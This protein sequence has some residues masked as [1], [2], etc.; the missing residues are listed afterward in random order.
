MSLEVTSHILLNRIVSAYKIGLRWKSE[1]RDVVML[2]PNM[3][4]FVDFLYGYRSVQLRSNLWFGFDD[5]A[6]HPQI[7]DKRVPHLPLIP[8]AAG[9]GDDPRMEILWTELQEHDFEAASSA[10]TSAFIGLGTIRQSYRSFLELEFERV[11]KR[12]L[13]IEDEELKFNVTNDFRIRS[14]KHHGRFITRQLAHPATFQEL[15]IWCRRCQRLILEFYARLRWLTD[16][17]PRL[18]AR[19]IPTRRRELLPVVGVIVTD[20]EL[21]T[22]LCKVWFFFC[23]H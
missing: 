14:Y 18:Q 10:D 8:T 16:I 12:S 3:D 23:S 2:S 15:Q 7:W 20:R 1:N 13:S 4:S 5:P 11:K 6:V 9:P 21:G 17:C 22:S 19:Q